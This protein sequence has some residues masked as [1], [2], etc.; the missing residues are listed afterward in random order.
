MATAENKFMSAGS[1]YPERRSAARF[2]F[3]AEAQINDPVERTSMSGCVTMIS[4]RGCFVKVE[5]PLNGGTVMKVRIQ[6][7][8]TAFETWARVADQRSNA[9]DGMSLVFIGTEPEQ[10]QVLESW[11]GNL[12]PSRC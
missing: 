12:A 3:S 10:A 6:N 2:A 4:K 9:T 7:G 1:R 5:K 8:D 11:L